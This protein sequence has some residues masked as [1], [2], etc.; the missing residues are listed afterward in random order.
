MCSIDKSNQWIMSVIP[1]YSQKNCLCP[2]RLFCPTWHW[3]FPFS[4]TSYFHPCP[5]LA[6]LINSLRTGS[7]NLSVLLIKCTAFNI[8][9]DLSINRLNKTPSF[10]FDFKAKLE[11]FSVSL[12][13]DVLLFSALYH[14][15]RLQTDRKS[16]GM[17]S[18]TA[19]H[20]RSWNSEALTFSL[21]KWPYPLVIVKRVGNYYFA[22]NGLID[23]STLSA[24]F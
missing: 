18:I 4:S 10:W 6:S 11:V 7:R 22:A 13:R 24:F 14:T 5:L 16:N 23:V 15:H 19:S 17:K 3:I 12:M 1:F 9:K 21:V 2:T 8:W 20:L